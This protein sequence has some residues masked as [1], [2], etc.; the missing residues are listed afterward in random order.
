[1]PDTYSFDAAD[2]LNVTVEVNYD[3]V[4]E[5]ADVAG[6]Q[7]KVNNVIRKNISLPKFRNGRIYKLKLILGVTSVQ[8][9][10]EA[11]DWTT[12]AQDVELPRNLD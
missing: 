5:S 2:A 3:V 6:G 7:V 9:E 1:M 11:A 12:D 10:A 8:F 4:T